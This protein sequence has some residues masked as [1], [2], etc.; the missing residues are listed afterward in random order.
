MDIALRARCGGC[1][2]RLIKRLLRCGVRCFGNRPRG[3]CPLIT[4]DAS[5]VQSPAQ[6]RHQHI[7][8]D[9]DDGQDD[10]I[11]AAEGRKIQGFIRFIRYDAVAMSLLTFSAA[12]CHASLS[13]R[14][15]TG[16]KPDCRHDAVMI[17]ASTPV[18]FN[19]Q[20][21]NNPL[22]RQLTPVMPVRRRTSS[23]AR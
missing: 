1:G 6:Q 18:Y 5:S 20:T 21:L 4:L 13:I 9:R 14:L 22:F 7:Q 11:L 3:S 2:S 16:A 19:K 10:G 17:T 23:I 15:E 8:R 12:S